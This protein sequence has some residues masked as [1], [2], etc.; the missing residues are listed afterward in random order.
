MGGRKWKR[1]MGEKRTREP[2]V[3]RQ[4]NERYASERKGSEPS[5]PDLEDIQKQKLVKTLLN[6]QTINLARRQGHSS[7]KKTLKIK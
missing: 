5:H 3:T 6:P 7:K 1:R 2:K 4:I